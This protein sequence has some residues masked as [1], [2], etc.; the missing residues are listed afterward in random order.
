MPL[1]AAA[2]TMSGLR[3]TPLPMPRRFPATSP[4]QACGLR[5]STWTN[6]HILFHFYFIYYNICF[7]LR[8]PVD[9]GSGAAL[10]QQP[11][12]IDRQNLYKDM[13]GVGETYRLNCISS[14]EENFTSM[15]MNLYEDMVGVSG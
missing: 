10:P 1:P 13:V 5:Q 4:P 14:R 7:V 6:I 2:K 11:G 9:C 15:G 8:R 12:Y 3:S